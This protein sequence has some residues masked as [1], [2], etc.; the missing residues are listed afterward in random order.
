MA[1]GDTCLSFQPLFLG[2]QVEKMLQERNVVFTVTQRRDDD[3]YDVEPIKQVLAKGPFSISFN[4]S[5]FDAA[6]THARQP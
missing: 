2:M 4:K 5:L 6:S 3:Q 1:S